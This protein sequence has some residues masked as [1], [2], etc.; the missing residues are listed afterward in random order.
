MTI[1]QNPSRQN[2]S[3][4]TDRTSEG[5]PA[6]VVVLVGNPRAG[7]RTLAV[8][9]LVAERSASRLGIDGAVETIDLAT[10]GG[11]VLTG[12][13]GVDDA[14]R[15]LGEATLTVVATPV[16]K[17]SY[18]GLLKAFLDRLPAGG[19]AG[20]AAVPVV[21]SAAPHHAAAGERHLA[22]LLAE[23][24]ATLPARPLSVLESEIPHADQVVRRWLD[25]SVGHLA[26]AVHAPRAGGV[27]SDAVTPHVVLAGGAR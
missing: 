7:S 1:E 13:E 5:H 14:L 4:Q 22:P 19:L 8:A 15:T 18:T 3:H 24:G 20:V 27:S 16:Y 9:R 12:G 25:E 17:G 6:R 23:L 10:L 2:P 26:R 11:R 21:V